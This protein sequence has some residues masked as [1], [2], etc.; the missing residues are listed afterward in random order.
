[1]SDFT[2][3]NLKF[4]AWITEYGIRRLYSENRDYFSQI[5]M[6]DEALKEK[7]KI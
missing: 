6:S 3:N 1:M 2:N 4:H 5:G 7:L